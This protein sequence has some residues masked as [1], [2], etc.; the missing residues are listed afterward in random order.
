MIKHIHR[1]I[2]KNFLKTF[3]ITFLA[4]IFILVMQFMFRY[5][6]DFVG[7]GFGALVLLEFLFYAALSVVPLALPLSILLGSLMTFGNL[8]ERLEL[9]AMKAAG[10]SLFKIMK[11]LIILIALVSIGSFYFANHILPATQVRMWGLLFSIQEASPELEIPQGAFYNGIKGRNVYTETKRNGL[12]LDVVIYDYSNGFNN[13]GIILADTG[14]LRLTEDKK[15]LV[16]ELYNGECFEN[17]QNGNQQANN[18]IIP[19][20]RETFSRKELVIDFDANFKELET[21]FL[22]D[23]YVAKNVDQLNQTVDSITLRLGAHITVEQE[24]KRRNTYFNRSNKGAEDVTIFKDSSINLT[25]QP[26]LQVHF[27]KLTN[28]NKKTVLNAALK[29]IKQ[30]NNKQES[31][32]STSEWLKNEIRRHEIEKYKRYTLSFACF[33]F[34]F[35]GAPLGAIIRKGG[36]GMPVVLS[37]ILFIIYYIIDNTGYKMAREGVWEVWQ[38]MW[39]SAFILLP[40]G[41]LLTYM[42]ATESSIMNGESYT[43]LLKKFF[44]KQNI[45]YKTIVKIKQK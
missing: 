5:V 25:E 16:L 40:F 36:M 42:A 26:T 9:L 8:G 24:K 15:Q 7:K 2:L 31:F 19:Y 3:S 10:I 12:L 11:S 23:Q 44:S 18:K 38:G 6:D 41:I 39:L 13:T 33:I 35:I 37:T 27:S 17:L 29:N 1:Y 30:I 20:R 4:S 32:N 21:T 45:I 34:L 14:R 28:N 22:E 43:M